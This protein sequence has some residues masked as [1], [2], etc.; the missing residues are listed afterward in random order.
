MPHYKSS[1][2]PAGEEQPGR[3]F[4]A[5]P[6]TSSEQDAE[7]I[8]RHSSGKIRGGTRFKEPHFEDL[9]EPEDSQILV[10]P[11]VELADVEAG[12][13]QA[14]TQRPDITA[15]IGFNDEARQ[16]VSEGTP[17][18]SEVVFVEDEP[19][20]APIFVEDEPAPAPI[21]VEDEPAPAPI[22]TA[23]LAAYAAHQAQTTAFAAVDADIKKATVPDILASPV[24]AASPVLMAYPEHAPAPSLIITPPTRTLP[25]PTARLAT[26]KPAAA[27]APA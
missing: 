3:H 17:L 5:P 11:G 21:F 6:D 10:F 12:P 7:P 27:P 19:A 20:P 1:D 22:A 25:A 15:Q 13:S 4:A 16:D 24:P 23:K 8:G 26:T 14:E 2:D 9:N 18:N